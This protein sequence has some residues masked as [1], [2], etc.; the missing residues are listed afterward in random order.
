MWL[1]G[2]RVVPMIATYS[3]HQQYV[4]CLKGNVV[5]SLEFSW[6][7]VAMLALH[8]WWPP[9]PNP[10]QDQRSSS[11]VLIKP[12]TASLNAPLVFWNAGFTSSTQRSEWPQTGSAPSLMHALFCTTWPLIYESPR[13]MMVWLVTRSM[14]CM[15]N[16]E[17]LTMEMR[18]EGTSQTL[19]LEGTLNLWGYIDV[20]FTGCSQSF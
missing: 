18:S 6:V 14:T 9:I 7:T 1:H 15:K 16:I 10:A 11:I 4:D 2:G 5:L 8:C 17:A 12:P 13:W 3:G 20:K 19:S